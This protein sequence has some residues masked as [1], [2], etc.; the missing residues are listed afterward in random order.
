MK[1][2]ENMKKEELA[3]SIL[4]R[5]QQSIIKQYYVLT[6]VITSMKLSPIS[7]ECVLETDGEQIFYQPATICR[8]AKQKELKTLQKWYMHLIVHGLLF[9]YVDYRKY[10]VLTLANAVF[11]LE[12]DLFL[13][14]LKSRKDAISGSMFDSMS[15]EARMNKLLEEKGAAALYEAAVKSKSL[16]RC[17][18][19]KAKEISLD[20]HENW[21]GKRNLQLFW[22]RMMQSCMAKTGLSLNELVG[23]MKGEKREYGNTSMGMETVVKKDDSKPLDYATVLREFFQERESCRMDPDSF[24]RDFYALGMEMYEDVVLLE[25]RE[26]GEKISMGTIVLAIDTSGSCAGNIIEKFVTQTEGLLHTISRIDYQELV[27]FQADAEICSEMHLK[28]GDPIPDCSR[29]SVCGFGG[30][31][32]RPVFQRVEEM[33][34]ETAV[35]VLIYLTDAYGSYPQKAPGVKTFFVIPNLEEEKENVME[36]VPKWITCL[37][38]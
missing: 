12:V 8:M 17:I 31:D 10:S 38:I 26:D 16:R 14:R 33:S 5:V 32:F 29:M 19:K 4:K 20:C 7:T 35:D 3:K 22:T 28:Q 11:D 34:K 1:N 36:F 37:A 2:K 13:R 15:E 25:P 21:E 27:I 9:H 24:D 23:K 30:T 18:Y 6:P